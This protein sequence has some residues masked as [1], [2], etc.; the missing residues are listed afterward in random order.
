V[1]RSRHDA[2][3]VSRV[4]LTGLAGSLASAATALVCSR[5]ENGHAARPLNAVTHI[6]DGGPPPAHDG[7]GG[8]NTALGFAIHTGASIWWALFYEGLFG[9]WARRQPRNAVAAAALVAASAYVVDYF[10]VPRR[11]RPGF[12]SYLSGG[13][14]LALY[15]ALA[16][17]F[18][19][20][21]RLTRGR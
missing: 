9:A 15:A 7:P 13:S 10:V 16:G 5:I 4:L 8:R 6:F 21:A 2:P 19:A 14:M 12:E 11:F 1:K 18:A 20:A 17:G 3:P